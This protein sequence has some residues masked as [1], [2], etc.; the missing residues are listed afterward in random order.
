MS[1]KK[2]PMTIPEKLKVLKMCI[3]IA[4]VMMIVSVIA[5]YLEIRIITRNPL[6]EGI[7]QI[8]TY[9]AIVL[10]S[11]YA[12]IWG[13]KLIKPLKRSNSLYNVYGITH[14]ISFFVATIALAFCSLSFSQIL[15]IKLEATEYLEY[16]QA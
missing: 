13:V 5:L 10:F 2:K 1:S 7:S 11:V 6:E 16:L 8:A 12:L 4:A 15:E 14:Q 9:S 3:G